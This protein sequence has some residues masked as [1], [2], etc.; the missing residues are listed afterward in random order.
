MS[1]STN[2]QPTSPNTRLDSTRARALS[3]VP[4]V[5]LL[6][7]LAWWFQPTVACA[8]EVSAQREIDSGTAVRVDIAYGKLRIVAGAPG[9]VRV[10]G[11]IG[12]NIKQITLSRAGGAVEV[13]LKR[14]LLDWLISSWR[15]DEPPFKAELDIEVPVDT[16]LFVVSR[17]ASITI[18][19]IVGPIGIGVVSS[20]VIVRGNPARLDVE[21]ISGDLD[22][23][24]ET[25][26]L[27]ASTLSGQLHVRLPESQ[28]RL[29]SVT[30][31]V[32]LETDAIRSATITSVSG[33]V[34]F[35]GSVAADGK[36]KIETRSG[37]VHL[38]LGPDRGAKLGLS[39]SQ[40]EIINEIDGAEP[41]RDARGRRVLDLSFL[42]GGGSIKVDSQSGLI[43]LQRSAP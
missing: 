2:R 30:G 21:T 3:P 15:G 18:E 17:D 31:S 10:T 27:R 33:E 5:A 40:S 36:V 11:H 39:T 37:D 24:G 41:S 4:A 22:F 28:I 29:D 42:G 32:T 34:R 14:P 7:C 25:A 1:I 23:D 9:Q 16:P 6:L 43:I 26:S 38:T 13:R 8:T 12:E 35:E 19:G 20:S